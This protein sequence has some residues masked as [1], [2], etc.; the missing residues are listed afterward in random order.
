[1][2]PKELISFAH[3][4]KFLTGSKFRVRRSDFCGHDQKVNELIS[5]VKNWMQENNPDPGEGFLKRSKD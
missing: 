1:M 2:E 4:S 3:V 5:L